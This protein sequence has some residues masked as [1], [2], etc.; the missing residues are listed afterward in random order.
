M[1][2]PLILLFYLNDCQLAQTV[3]PACR[4]QQH[5]S[6]QHTPKTSQDQT[7]GM[8]I[9]QATVAPIQI[10]QPSTWDHQGQSPIAVCPPARQNWPGLT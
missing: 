9:Q 8:I 3:Q 1:L 6:Q 7:I 2:G 4:S 10:A 5:S